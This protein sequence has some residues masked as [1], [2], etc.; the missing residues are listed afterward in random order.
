MSTFCGRRLTTRDQRYRGL[1]FHDLRRTA[2]RNLRR[3]GIPESMIMKI[4]GWRT[5]SVFHRYAIVDRR[6][7][8]TAMRQFEAYEASKGRI[9][10]TFQEK[11]NAESENTKSEFGHSLGTIDDFQA[12]DNPEKKLQ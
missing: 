12:S 6:D 1:I 9:C 10:R 5:T 7:M 4:G 2:A 8:A 3:A 11:Q